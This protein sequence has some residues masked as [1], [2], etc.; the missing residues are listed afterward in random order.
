MPKREKVER[1]LNLVI[2]LLSTRQFVSAEYI[3]ANVGGYYENDSSDDAF[4]RMFERDKADLRE[5][6]IPVITGPTSGF[7]ETEDGYRSTGSATNCPTS[8]SSPT[9]RRRSHWPP[10]LGQLR[11]RGDRAE[12]GAQTARRRDRRSRRPGVGHRPGRRGRARHR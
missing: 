1:Q 11:G 3:R 2:C 7:G 10:R 8:T 4:Y 9:R 6:G 5:L 12:R